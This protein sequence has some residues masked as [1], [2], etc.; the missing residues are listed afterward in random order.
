VVSAVPD[1][2]REQIQRVRLP[3]VAYIGIRRNWS[4][5]EILELGGRVLPTPFACANLLH[6]AIRED[7]TIRQHA[8]SSRRSSSKVLSVESLVDAAHVT[9]VDDVAVRCS[10]RLRIAEAHYSDNAVRLQEFEGTRKEPRLSIARN[11]VKEHEPPKL[12]SSPSGCGK[13]IC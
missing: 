11:R 8:K 3:L 1:A 7:T 4:S 12:N 6:S 2:R 13:D 9:E 5:T 10:A